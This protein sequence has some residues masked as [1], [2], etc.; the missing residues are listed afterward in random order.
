MEGDAQIWIQRKKLL[1]AHMEW[2]EFKYELM[3]RFG[4]PPYEDGFGE[5]CK[6][7]QTSSVRNYQSRFERLLGKVG[8][9]TDLQETTYFLGGLKESIRVDVRAQNPIAFS[10]AISLAC[11][12]E[13]KNQEVKQGSTE[14]RPN[15]FA[16]K[17]PNQGT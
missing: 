6:L 9:L 4:L 12:Y 8:T 7:K 15:L 13:G 14:Y 3:L 11:I 17:A 2:E 10:S 16:N 1:K 5:L